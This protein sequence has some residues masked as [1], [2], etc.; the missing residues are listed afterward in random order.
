MKIWQLA[1]LCWISMTVGD[2]LYEQ[3]TGKKRFL[4]SLKTSWDVAWAIG[5]FIMGIYLLCK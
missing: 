2:F 1:I 4:R 5:F 3:A